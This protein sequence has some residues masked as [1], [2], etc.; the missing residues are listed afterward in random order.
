MQMYKVFFKESCFLLCD[1]QNLLKNGTVSLI[2]KDFNETKTFILGQLNEKEKFY[3]VILYDDLE[4]LFSVFK[5]CF[6]YVKAAGGI[7]INN[8]H[9]LMIKRLGMPDL[10]KGHIESGESIEQ[11]AIR[12]V[13][14]EC[15]IHD[16]SITGPLTDTLHIYSRNE[17][18]YLKKTY[19]YT[20]DC[21]PGQ[22]LTP[23]TEEDI[24]EVYWLPMNEISNILD[25]TYPSLKTVL[26][27][28][29]NE[30]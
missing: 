8:S 10:P 20:M 11:C 22:H 3:A 2:H 21:T 15:G 6:L 13:E 23:Q 30:K 7:V 28:V 16:L 19:W 9:I 1:D 27:K 5:S 4:V 18:W 17:N 25:N 29:K 12:E 24:E 26:Q 14:E